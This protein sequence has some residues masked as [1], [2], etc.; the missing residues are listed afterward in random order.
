MF[1]LMV[2]DESISNQLTMFIRNS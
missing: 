2:T 1:G